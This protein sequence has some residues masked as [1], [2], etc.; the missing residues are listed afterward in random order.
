[1]QAS[2]SGASGETFEFWR[3]VVER[4]TR[5]AHADSVLAALAARPGYGFY[6]IAA[7]ETLGM[8][9]WPGVPPAADTLG[10]GREPMLDLAE[11]LAALGARDDALLVLQRWIN[12]ATSAASDPFR[13]GSTTRFAPPR[14]PGWLRA[15]RLAYALGRTPAGIRVASLGLATL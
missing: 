15:A 11:S 8:G 9:G 14:F 13:E 10:P 7:R 12:S 2:W 1:A 6:S 4:G 3:A 5:R